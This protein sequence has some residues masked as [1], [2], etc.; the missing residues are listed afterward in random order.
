MII[1]TGADVS[2][3]TLE[4]KDLSV[5]GNY[6][7]QN[8][9][10]FTS[11]TAP[12]TSNAGVGISLCWNTISCVTTVDV[13]STATISSS[14]E[15]TFLARLIENYDTPFTTSGPMLMSWLSG[16][17]DVSANG[18]LSIAAYGESVVPIPPA[19]YLFGSGVIGLVGMAKRRTQKLNSSTINK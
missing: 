14:S 15:W 12:E 3:F 8:S 2:F 10:S 13:G 17:F 18:V 1:P 7:N 9:I 6:G 11:I 4:V 5:S 16:G 19:L